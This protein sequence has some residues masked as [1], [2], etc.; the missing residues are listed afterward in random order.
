M[1]RMMVPSGPYTISAS[2][3]S[4]LPYDAVRQSAQPDATLL[5]FLQSTY[6]AGARLAAPAMGRT[7][8]SG[9]A[10]AVVAVRLRTFLTGDAGVSAELCAWLVEDASCGR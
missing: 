1:V 5:D 7:S 3:Y 6:E 9:Q 2:V 8:A 10:R 4:N